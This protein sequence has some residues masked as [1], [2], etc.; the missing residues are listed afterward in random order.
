MDNEPFSLFI[1]N[2]FAC[3]FY[4]FC[5]PIPAPSLTMADSAKPVQLSNSTASGTSS[6]SSLITYRVFEMEVVAGGECI[7]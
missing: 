5:F 6:S 1:I 7:I 4:L 2:G 3:Y